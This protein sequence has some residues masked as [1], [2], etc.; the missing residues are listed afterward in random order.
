MIHH[1]LPNI[2]GHDGDI[3]GNDLI[4]MGPHEE[5]VKVQSYMHIYAPFLYSLFFLNKFFV[6]DFKTFSKI[7]SRFIKDKKKEK[8]LLLG[9]I[10]RKAIYLGFTL[11]IPT[12]FLPHSFLSI[13]LTFLCFHFSTSIL[14]G[15]ILGGSHS[16]LHNTFQIPNEDNFID[17]SYYRHQIETAVDFCA[18]NKLTLFMF[19][20]TNAH[21]AHHLYP[22]MSS[23]HYGHVSKILE[24][25]S[26][27]Y[28]MKYVNLSFIKYITGHWKY[29]RESS[30]NSKVFLSSLKK[31]Q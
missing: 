28:E 11:G 22:N 2:P 19:G 26:P 14:I 4:R 30:R 8:L 27:K 1:P 23:A 18:T 24:E 5:H 29:L 13:F 12:Y 6:K 21:V 25:I 3:V 10:L 7:S 17:Q 16:S 15:F 31:T 9:I 20:S